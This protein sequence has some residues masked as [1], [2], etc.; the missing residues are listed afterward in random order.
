MGE[1]LWPQLRLEAESLAELAERYREV[2]L[3][4]YVKD[5]EGN[6]R[7]FTDWNGYTYRFAARQFDHAFSKA[8][9]YRAGTGVHDGGWC[10]KRLRRI[11]WIREVLALS[12]GTVQRYSQVRQNMRGKNVKRRTL[13]VLEEKY[14][15]VFDD[16]KKPGQPFHFVT[17][18]PADETY[19]S[20]VIRQKS[21]H[22]ETKKAQPSAAPSKEKCPSLIGD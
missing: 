7:T 8:S 21:C 5:E 22:L 17:A 11:L 15:V 13:V 1:S 14:V 10:R 12:A 6:Q 18:F 3:K 19:L 9:N 20:K 16:P 2:Y 4:T